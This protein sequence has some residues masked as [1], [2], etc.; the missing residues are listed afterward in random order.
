MISSRPLFSRCGG[1]PRSRP[2]AFL[3]VPPLP[4][5]SLPPVC[6]YFAP[7][8][9][10]APRPS[11]RT[12]AAAAMLTVG[13]QV[14]VLWGEHVFEWRASGVRHPHRLIVRILGWIP[15]NLRTVRILEWT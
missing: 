15:W 7:C 13:N 8:Y 5:D 1:W 14:R 11:D 3:H 2:A 12:W 10:S 4:S 9:E 6:L